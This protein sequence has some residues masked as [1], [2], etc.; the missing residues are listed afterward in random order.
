MKRV[1]LN[2]LVVTVMVI[3]ALSSCGKYNN[4]NEKLLEIITIDSGPYTKIEYDDKNRILKMSSYTETGELSYLETFTYS[5]NDLVKTVG[6]FFSY[7]EDEYKITREF[8]KTENII[9]I[10]QVSGGL[11]STSTLYLNSDELPIKCVTETISGSYVTNY[12]IENGNLVKVANEE[13]FGETKS[14][15]YKYGNKKSPYYSCKTPKW[16]MFWQ[17]GEMGS[18]NNVTEMKSSDDWSIKNDYVFDS[19]GYPTKRTQRSSVEGAKA[20]IFE[21]NYK[22]LLPDVGRE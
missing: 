8:T 3:V 5:G 21:F 17:A 1:I 22:D 2:Y 9:S 12:Q 16:Y 4:R 18:R 7:S 20:T 10:M 14:T 19:D 15:E 6:E 13:T 11:L